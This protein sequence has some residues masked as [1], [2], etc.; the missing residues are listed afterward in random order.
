[1][2]RQHLSGCQHS[3]IAAL[4]ALT[5]QHLGSELLANA[6]QPPQTLIWLEMWDFQG[7]PALRTRQRSVMFLPASQET[8]QTKAMP[9]LGGH[10]AG[11]IVQA[12]ETS[13]FFPEVLHQICCGHFLKEGHQSKIMPLFWD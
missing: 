10:W 3:L 7:P 8:H 6:S 11:E 12:D 13:Q 9:T 4:V 1:M 5:L 2:I